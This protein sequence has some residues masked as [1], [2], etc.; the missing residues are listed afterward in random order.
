M[1]NQETLLKMWLHTSDS[2]YINL[3]IALYY[4][5]HMMDGYVLGGAAG[6]EKHTALKHCQ[7]TL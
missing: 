3:G 2:A 6:L 7:R 1:E 4:M 5:A